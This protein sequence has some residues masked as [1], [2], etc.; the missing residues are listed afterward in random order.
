M[1]KT[2]PAKKPRKRGKADPKWQTGDYER[3]ARFSFILPEPFLML[4][5]LCDVTPEEMLTDFIDNLSHRSWKR[6]G[7]E[8]AKAHLVAYFLAHGYGQHHY[9][10]EELRRMF[11][12]LDAVGLLFPQNAKAIL[13]DR[14]IAWRDKHYPFWFKQWFRKARR[15]LQNAPT[16]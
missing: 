2:T 4:C 3:R 10:E 9:T 11:Q 13:F 16:A 6:E 12:E 8:G 15:K 14:Y 5:R 7:R 1:K